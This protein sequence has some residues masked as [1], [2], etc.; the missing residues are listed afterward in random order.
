[1]VAMGRQPCARREV[2]SGLGEGNYYK[3]NVIDQVYRY[4]EVN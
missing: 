3:R 2:G 4:S 1:M